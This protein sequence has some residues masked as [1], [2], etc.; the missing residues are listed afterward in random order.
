MFRA[1]SCGDHGQVQMVSVNLLAVT[2]WTACAGFPYHKMQM[3]WNVFW[4]HF[5][6]VSLGCKTSLTATRDCRSVSAVANIFYDNWSIHLSSYIVHATSSHPLA[7]FKLWL[8]KPKW[9][10]VDL[11]CSCLLALSLSKFS[12]LFPK[13][14]CRFSYGWLT[15]PVETQYFWRT[16]SLTGQCR[17]INRGFHVQKPLR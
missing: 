3:C 17:Q 10:W 14:P 2:T 5:A 16:H 13:V 4:S 6:F 1:W 12:V 7:S 15:Q 11:Q 9:H 8:N